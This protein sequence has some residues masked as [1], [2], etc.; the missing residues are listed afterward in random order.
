M[1]NAQLKIIFAYA[2]SPV[3][4]ETLVIRSHDIRI[5]FTIMFSD[6]E[7]IIKKLVLF[8]LQAWLLI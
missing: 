8:M 3:N 6:V 5:M 2:A 1:S 4:S 7:R